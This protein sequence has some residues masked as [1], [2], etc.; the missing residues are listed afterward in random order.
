MKSLHRILS[1]VLAAIAD[2]G[3]DEDDREELRE[4]A[5]QLMDIPS[6]ELARVLGVPA[7]TIRRWRADH[8]ADHRW[9]RDRRILALAE[10]GIRVKEI[11]QL[12]R[13]SVRLVYKVLAAHGEGKTLA[14]PRLF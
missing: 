10:R 2:H 4:L 3:D 7:R 14:G 13:V 6:A 5:M 12:M 11:A 9:E 1:D 8:L